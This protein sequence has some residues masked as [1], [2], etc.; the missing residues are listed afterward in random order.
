MATGQLIVTRGSAGGSIASI[1][2]QQQSRIV[3]NAPYTATNIR[4]WYS[5]LPSGVGT[6]ASDITVK[7]AIWVNGTAYQLLFSGSSTLTAAPGGYYKSDIVSGLSIAAGDTVEVRTYAT[8]ASGSDM[9]VTQYLVANLGDGHEYGASLTD[10]TMS[11]TIT[12][13]AAS[14]SHQQ[15]YTPIGVFG[16]TTGTTP[17]AYIDGDSISIGT[18]D[19]LDVV[20][21]LGIACNYNDIPYCRGGAGGST[22]GAAVTRSALALVQDILGRVSHYCWEY[23]VND[24]S[25]SAS[26]AT[27]IANFQTVRGVAVGLNPTIKSSMATVMPVTDT[28]NVAPANNG[29]WNSTKEAVRV[30]YNNLIRANFASYGA[31]AVWEAAGDAS[32]A[33]GLHKGA[34]ATKDGGR[35]RDDYSSQNGFSIGSTVA[36]GLH[37]GRPLI[38]AAAG[39]IDVESFFGVAPKWGP[40]LVYARASSDGKYLVLNFLEKKGVKSPLASALTS[41]GLTCTVSAAGRTVQFVERVGDWTAYLGFHRRL[42]TSEIMTVVTAANNGITDVG[43]NKS[44]A[45][46]VVGTSA[47]SYTLP[48]FDGVAL[49]EDQFT[50]ADTSYNASAGNSTA[51]TGWVD[52]SGNMLKIASN[53]LSVQ[54]N[55]SRIGYRSESQLDSVAEVIFD[56]AWFTASDSIPFG[57]KIGLRWNT[58]GTD[59]SAGNTNGIFVFI[60]RN[61]DSGFGTLKRITIINSSSAG[62]IA[63]L[64]NATVNWTN[65]ITY[66]VRFVCTGTT[67]GGNK[68][69]YAT[70]YNNSTGAQIATVTSTNAN[71]SN[72][73]GR[74]CLVSAPAATNSLGTSVATEVLLDNFKSL[75][76][77]E[78]NPPTITDAAIPATGEYVDL[79]LSDAR[80]P[81][82]PA[83]SAAGFTITKG[84]SP[85]VGGSLVLWG[86][87]FARYQLPLPAKDGEIFAWSYDPTTGNITD[88]NAPTANEIASSSGSI[89]NNS[90]VP[91][92][93]NNDEEIMTIS[94]PTRG[95]SATAGAAELLAQ[96]GDIVE[97]QVQG[98][99]AG[100]Y[101]CAVAAGDPA[102]DPTDPDV[103]AFQLGM[104]GASERAYELSGQDLYGW[105][106]AGACKFILNGT[107]AAL[108]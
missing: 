68:V 22:S 107:M 81:I 7:G 44:E 23:G 105:S 37:P 79:T 34:E 59:P 57:F 18:G 9:M 104:R 108:P 21:Y 101:V 103:V 102:P 61:A 28:S 95:V 62:E 51:G 53:R 85:V 43:S 90:T 100:G 106:A 12:A 36:D 8:V 89:T 65:G 60:N 31:D 47:S 54:G 76:L 52:N 78:S 72:I 71:I 33:S 2:R 92:T 74:I 45:Q 70:V 13:A 56:P 32:G 20:G 91:S 17:A 35:F 16:D 98:N 46:T 58:S 63:G 93:N 69:C 24:F 5:G 73:A 75:S 3:Y 80:L 10:K 83:T 86:D 64:A 1:G 4:V 26:A 19:A 49:V 48:S 42:Q 99:T 25:S 29:Y 66:R 97:V 87:N 41:T 6:L 30:A 27:V 55:N 94:S 88:S 15:G 38:L 84:G 39:G 14:P 96:D 11:G 40:H 77:T 67:A 50:R 82:S